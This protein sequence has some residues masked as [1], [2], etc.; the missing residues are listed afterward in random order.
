VKVQK[1]DKRFKGTYRMRKVLVTFLA[2]GSLL[3]ISAVTAMADDVTIT[4]TV[5][6]NSCVPNVTPA[7]W[8]PD[9]TPIVDT[10]DLADPT[11]PPTENFAV[12]LNF[13]DGFD[14]NICDPTAEY[15]PTG[16][17]TSTFAGTLVL[18]TMECLDDPCSAAFISNDSFNGELTGAYNVP[19]TAGTYSGTLRI[20]WTP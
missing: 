6:D 11:T 3:G 16:N 5:E 7:D 8:R 12:L 10:F 15:E 18:S 2:I 17:I 14:V 20:T 1:L 13:E 19:D 4:V 9:L